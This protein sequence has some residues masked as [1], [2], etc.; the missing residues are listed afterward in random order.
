MLSKAPPAGL[1][2]HHRL[3]FDAIAWAGVFRV[4]RQ[5]HWTL[6]VKRS[7]EIDGEEGGGSG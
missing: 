6:K 7:D 3:S 1:M 5:A 2:L 4:F